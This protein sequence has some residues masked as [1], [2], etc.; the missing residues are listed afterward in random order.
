[1]TG[2]KINPFATPK[3]IIPNHIRKNMVKIYDL[4]VDRTTIARK[5]EKAPWKTDG[6]IAPRAPRA[7][8]ILFS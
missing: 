5:V 1:M 4:E 6:P 2:K 7:L 3:I 8:K